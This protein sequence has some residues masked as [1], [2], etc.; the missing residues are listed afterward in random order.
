[1][2]QHNKTKPEC[3]NA[4]LFE[5]PSFRYC[6]TILGAQMSR[7]I[8]HP[9]RRRSQ[10]ILFI[11]TLFSR[12]L[13]GGWRFGMEQQQAAARSSKQPR[14]NSGVCFCRHRCCFQKPTKDG[15][16]QPAVLKAC[17]LR[18]KV[19]KAAHSQC[20]QRSKFCCSAATS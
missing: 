9:S 11:I 15:A 20:H 4:V 2:V 7:F 18:G 8:T 3:G 12:R 17:S 6:L 16:L 5:K 10:L 1:M 13:A 14:C 19:F